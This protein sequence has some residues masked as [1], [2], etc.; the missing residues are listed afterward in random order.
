MRLGLSS[1]IH[2]FGQIALP[3][4]PCLILIEKANLVGQL[5]E[6]ASEVLKV[7][8]LLYIPLNNAKAGAKPAPGDQPH[9]DMIENIQANKS[10]YFSFRL[11]LTKTMQTVLQELV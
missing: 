11:D 1:T 8:K 9:I 7:E 10:F 4:G 2:G 6:T 5:I 3:S